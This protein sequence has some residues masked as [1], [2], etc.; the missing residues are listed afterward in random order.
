[1]FERRIVPCWSRIIFQ[2]TSRNLSFPD[3][4]LA[5]ISGIAAVLREAT[6]IPYLAGLWSYERLPS[7]LQWYV[8]SS[9][10]ELLPRPARKACAPSWSWA[11]VDSRSI[12][13]N[14]RSILQS[15]QIISANVSNE[16][17]SSVTGCVTVQGPMRSGSWWFGEGTFQFGTQSLDYTAFSCP[18]NSFT[19][20]P[21]CCDEIVTREKNTLKVLPT[22]LSFLAIGRS[23][24]SQELIRGLVLR[25]VSSH[26]YT[27][28]GHFEAIDQGDF[29]VNNWTTQVAS[30]N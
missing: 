18:D 10:E 5:A 7:L 28:V 20:W 23:D 11:S 24:V 26:H 3:D 9:P 19:I 4:K 15:V 6:N 17:G 2:Y 30:V 27:R 14:S 22:E 29:E 13:R 8:V 25:K 21:D 1:M 12:F 16:F